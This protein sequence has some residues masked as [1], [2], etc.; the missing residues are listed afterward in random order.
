MYVLYVGTINKTSSNDFP[1]GVMYGMA[2]TGGAVA[3]AIWFWSDK[4]MKKMKN[5]K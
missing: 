2:G 3:V 5:V 4:K 1:V